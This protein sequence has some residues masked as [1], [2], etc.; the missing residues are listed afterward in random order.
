MFYTTVRKLEVQVV[1]GE[2]YVSVMTPDLLEIP[3]DIRRKFFRTFTK[4]NDLY[5]W[6]IDNVLSDLKKGSTKTE[7]EGIDSL[8]SSIKTLLD[9]VFQEVIRRN[10]QE[11]EGYHLRPPQLESLSDFSDY[12]DNVSGFRDEL[13]ESLQRVQDWDN[14]P[15][16][17]YYDSMLDVIFREI[18]NFLL[19]NSSWDGTPDILKVSCDDGDVGYRWLFQPRVYEPLPEDRVMKED[20]S[21]STV[22]E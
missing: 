6:R 14:E 8:L 15:T 1:D 11:V 12:P 9:K 5:Q 22:M 2:T 10:V 17:E 4:W 20:P 13:E 21:H 16:I 3:S 19:V 18:R 7:I